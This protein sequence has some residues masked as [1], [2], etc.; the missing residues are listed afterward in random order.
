[1][2]RWLSDKVSMYHRS[3]VR[4]IKN[5]NV[6]PIIKVLILSDF[7]IWSAR[8]LII[9]IFAVFIIMKIPGAGVVE[10][11]IATA[12]YLIVRSVFETPIGLYIDQSKSEKD[13]FITMVLGSILMGVAFFIFPHIETILGLYIIQALI[14]LAAAISYPG[15]MSIFT[16]HIDKGRVAF[17]WSLYDVI[18]GLGMAG[19]AAVGG[20]LVEYFGFDLLFYVVGSLIIVGALLLIYIRKKIRK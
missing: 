13:D 9:P 6:N 10:V 18:T 20:F 8:N 5:L 17:E 16:N 12:I 3:V 7:L 2:I 1:M 11:G 4:S 15:W 14:G 19:A